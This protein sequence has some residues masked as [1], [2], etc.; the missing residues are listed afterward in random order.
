VRD[1]GTTDAYADAV[2]IDVL[3]LCGVFGNISDEDVQTTV[4]ALPSL[5]A[6]DATVIWTRHRGEPDLT[7]TI[8]R[9]FREAGFE[10]QAFD[11][12][13]PGTASFSVG[14]ARLVAEPRHY[15]AGRR[16]FSFTR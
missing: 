16:L 8:R 7:P 4:Q 1:A 12:P 11:S 10:E 15:E 9:W 2:P 6:L 13:G 14:A 5:C 3:L